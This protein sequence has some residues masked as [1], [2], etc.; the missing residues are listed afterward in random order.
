ML[1]DGEFE[2][3]EIEVEVAQSGGGMP[4]GQ[5]DMPGMPPG[6]R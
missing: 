3:K 2:H 1:R 5:I 6:C 4:I